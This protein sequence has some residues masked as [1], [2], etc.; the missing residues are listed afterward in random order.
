MPRLDS[1][2]KPSFARAKLK[3]GKATRVL[4]K[5]VVTR[6]FFVK[7]CLTR[8]KLKDGR[9]RFSRQT[10][11]RA[12]EIESVRHPRR[13]ARRFSRTPHLSIFRKRY[14]TTISFRENIKRYVIIE[15]RL[16]IPSW[17]IENRD[18]SLGSLFHVSPSPREK[19]EWKEEINPIF[20]N[21]HASKN[22][23]APRI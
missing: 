2:V 16:D 9:I 21:L 18:R 22:D 20:A 5:L 23:F 8:A 1:L 3:D 14:A 17:N 12:S 7:V 10:F 15:K 13:I 19:S 4:F 11:L 6:D